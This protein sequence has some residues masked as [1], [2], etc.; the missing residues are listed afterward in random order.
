V[1]SVFCGR[2]GSIR[3]QQVEVAGPRIPQAC[4]GRTTWLAV[5][6]PFEDQRGQADADDE[7]ADRVVLGDLA[8]PDR[9]EVATWA[10]TPR[11]PEH[12]IAPKPRPA[13]R[14]TLR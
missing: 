10:S 1:R 14:V 5:Q 9:T 13:G 7:V 6:V 8:D 11:S 12:G 2:A 4:T 3:A